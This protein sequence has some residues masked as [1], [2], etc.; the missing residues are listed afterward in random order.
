[1][2][3]WWFKLHGRGR[4]SEGWELRL[5]GQQASGDLQPPPG[6]SDPGE[7]MQPG[8]AHPPQ[9]QRLGPGT[10]IAIPP[11][12][13]TAHELRGEWL[14]LPPLYPAPGPLP[15]LEDP[16]PSP[17]ASGAP[18]GRGGGG[19]LLLRPGVW[20]RSVAGPPWEGPCALHLP[21]PHTKAPTEAPHL[22][23]RGLRAPASGRAGW[24]EDGRAR[25]C[26]CPCV[27]QRECVN[28]CM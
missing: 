21:A 1:M 8:A 28:V 10:A 3:N 14:L 7:V 16:S 15:G 20:R 26:V 23:A 12:S 13:G 6:A 24:R 9:Q 17:G 5:T 27:C 22:P 2:G 4:R 18:W 11:L 19:R 25:V